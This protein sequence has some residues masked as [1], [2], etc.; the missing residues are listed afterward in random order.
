MS[1][2]GENL[3]YMFTATDSSAPFIR[4]ARITKHTRLPWPPPTADAG[5]GGSPAEA[6]RRRGGAARAAAPPGG[7]QP[8]RGVA[9]A[10]GAGGAVAR[11]GEPPHDAG[12]RHR[13]QGAFAFAA[14]QGAGPNE[15]TAMVS[16]R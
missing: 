8:R 10:H 5:R 3:R 7:G 12:E 1:S 13:V 4:P 16:E 6:P 15:G 9:T 11:A 14:R 2:R